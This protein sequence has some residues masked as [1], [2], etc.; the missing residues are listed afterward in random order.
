MLSW[1][2]S[3]RADVIKDTIMTIKTNGIIIKYLYKY[4]FCMAVTRKYVSVHWQQGY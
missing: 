2:I 4:V 3:L 1:K